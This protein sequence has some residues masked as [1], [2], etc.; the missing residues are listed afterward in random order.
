MRTYVKIIGVAL[1]LVAGVIGASALV[2]HCTPQLRPLTD[3]ELLVAVV[4][5]QVLTLLRQ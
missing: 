5:L 2:A 4:V 1:L 3:H